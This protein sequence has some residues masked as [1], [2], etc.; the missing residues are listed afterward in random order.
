MIELDV[1]VGADI[2]KPIHEIA[3]ALHIN[4]NSGYGKSGDI[5]LFLNEIRELAETSTVNIVKINFFI[6]IQK[7]YIP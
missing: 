7:I 2:A 1:T 4:I 3:D 5:D 6:E